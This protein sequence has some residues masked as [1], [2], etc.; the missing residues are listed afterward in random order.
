M[1]TFNDLVELAESGETEGKVIRSD[2]PRSAPVW[3]KVQVQATGVMVYTSASTSWV[4]EVDRLLHDE[5]L[6]QSIRMTAAMGRLPKL[7]HPAVLFESRD[8]QGGK[9]VGP[10]L[11]TDPTVPSTRNLGWHDIDYARKVARFYGV[12]LEAEL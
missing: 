10:V 1:K 12:E 3:R 11:I 9:P 2:V 8:I 6:R 4:Y 5:R 7:A